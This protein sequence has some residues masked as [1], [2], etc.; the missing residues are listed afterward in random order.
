MVA[1]SGNSAP[2]VSITSAF[3]NTGPVLLEMVKSVLAQTFQ[4]FE[5]VLLDDG[6]TDGS[7][8]LAESIV[9]P[10]VR[11][12][13]NGRN[14]GRSV[15]L[16]RLTGLARG[17]YIARMDSDDMCA[18]TRIQKQVE[19][20]EAGREL[21]AVGTGMMY[22]DRAGQ[23][24]GDWYANPSQAVICRQPR[25]IIGLA[26]GSMLAR[27]AWLA[28]Y[29]YDETLKLAVDY[30][31]L[32]RAYRESRFSNVPEPLYYY[33]FDPSFSLK[34]QFRTRRMVARFLYA[35]CRRAGRLDQAVWHWLIQYGKF[36]ATTLMFATGW[37]SRLMARRFKALSG[38][39]RAAYDAEL[40]KI[41]SLP[42]TLRPGCQR[43][44][45]V[46]ESR[47]EG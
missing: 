39:E 42:L 7:R 18:P 20:M 26:H 37:R 25:R 44:E 3:Y 35:D 17:K 43:A 47:P 15:S 30:S 27:R 38:A 40:E 12:F 41:R 11:V 28:K 13:T 19:L 36:A 5:L 6:S 4:D 9:D 32:L 1:A 45:L 31:L 46:A 23:P 22:L 21:D 16:N 2:L 33:R 10:R 34:K 8:A 29:R 24:L 14:L